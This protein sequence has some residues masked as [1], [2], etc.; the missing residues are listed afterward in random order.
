VSVRVLLTFT[1]ITPLI[2]QLIGTVTTSGSAT[3]VIN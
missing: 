3:M 2:G 1:P